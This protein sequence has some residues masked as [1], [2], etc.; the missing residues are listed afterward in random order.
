MKTIKEMKEIAK[1]ATKLTG[2]KWS[3]SKGTDGE[4]FLINEESECIYWNEIPT[5]WLSKETTNTG[6]RLTF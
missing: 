4:Y 6:K 2:E 3:Q 1:N 5:E